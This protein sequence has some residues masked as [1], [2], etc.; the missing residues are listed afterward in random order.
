VFIGAGPGAHDLLTVRA[1]ARLREADFIVHDRLVPEGLFTAIATSAECIPAPVPDAGEDRGAAVGRLLVEL[2]ASG[3]VVVRLKGGDAGI[4]SRLEE[5]LEPL[6]AA[7]VAIEFVPGVTAALAAAS[8]AGVP[9]TSRMSASSLTLVTGHDADGKSPALDFRR[10]ATVPGTIAVYMGVE[11]AAHWSE[12]L[13]AGGLD[14]AT[15]VT[16]VGQ[17]S[18]PDE[19]I[20]AS[21]LSRC[22]ADLASGGWQP[23]AVLLVG[24]TCRTVRTGPLRAAGV[25]LTR[26]TGQVDAL[27]SFVRAAGGRCLHVPLVTIEP[28]SSWEAL[29]AAIA[30]ADTFDWIVFAS[31][32]GVHAFVRRLRAGDRDGRALGTARLAVIGPATRDALESAGL[33]ADLAPAEFSSEGLLEVLADSPPRSRFL[34]VR[35]DRGRDVLRQT[36][37][38][39]GH[40]VEEVTAYRSI[41]VE[42]LDERRLAAIDAAGIDWVTV[43]SSRIAEAAVRIFGPRMRCWRIASL[44]PVTTATLRRHGLEP[45][46]EAREATMAGLVAAMAAAT[47]RVESAGDAPVARNV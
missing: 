2:A 5:E 43:T 44:S 46:V 21:T 6:E 3:R 15:P 26:P 1:T 17:C 22:A 23:P 14:P 24:Q 27:A 18:W 45:A 29:D 37:K 8:A 16:I 42:R 34:L 39:G 28:P 12:S 25:L 36:L 40:D 32:N 4:F 33:V 30:R 11:Q 47:G 13:M 19:R 38:A 20:A 41:P 9:L 35:A 31:V 10:L 7:G